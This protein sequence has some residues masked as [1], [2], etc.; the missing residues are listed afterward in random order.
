MKPGGVTPAMEELRSRDSP[1][2]TASIYHDNRAS[3]KQG[4]IPI[5]GSYNDRV[6][7]HNAA[8]PAG[9]RLRVYDRYLILHTNSAYH[10]RT[11][12]AQA[13]CVI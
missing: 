13:G 2:E 8:Q 6:V 12:R 10:L 5:N 11:R 1:P 4:S 9:P 7:A 3:L